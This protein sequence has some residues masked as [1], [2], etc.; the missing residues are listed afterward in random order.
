MAKSTW[1][2][3]NA[4]LEC[5]SEEFTLKAMG[6]DAADLQLEEGKE[7]CSNIA[8][9]KQ[10]LTAPFFL[11]GNGKHLPLIYLPKEC[12]FSV[13]QTVLGLIVIVPYGGCGVKQEVFSHLSQTY[14]C[15]IYSLLTQ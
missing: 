4:S 14:R 12:G 2:L 10:E 3:L 7:T 9:V 5:G 1:R 6:L 13:K 8:K 15:K 11:S